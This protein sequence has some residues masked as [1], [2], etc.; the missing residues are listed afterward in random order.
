MKRLHVHLNVE[1]IA[2]SVDFYRTLFSQEPSVLEPDY[3]KWDLSEPSV[4]FAIST[5]GTPGLQ[6][7]GIEAEDPEELSELY[8]RM[9]ALDAPKLAEGETTCCYACSEKS[10][11]QDPQNISWE[12]FHTLGHA[13]KFQSA[14]T[15]TA[16]CAPACCTS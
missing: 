16:C 8:S 13:D 7:L 4:N 12:L 15:E 5:Y 11:I 1:N 14:S 9:N 6:H 10:W 3:A 2:Q